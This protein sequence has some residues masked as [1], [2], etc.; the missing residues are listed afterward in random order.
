MPFGEQFIDQRQTGHD[1]R[2]KFTGKERDA[3]TGF[4]YFGA[5]YYDSGLSV[6]FAQP[7]KLHSLHKKDTAAKRRWVDP[8]ADKYLSTSPFMY[9][10]GN[11]IAFIDP[12]GMNH[13]YYENKYGDV[14]YRDGHA[15]SVKSGGEEY[16][17]IGSTYSKDN[18]DGTSTHYVQNTAVSVSRSD[19]SFGEVMQ[20]GKHF[21]NAMHVASQYDKET[22]QEVFDKTVATGTSQMSNDA[23]ALMGSIVVGVVGGE[24]LL[25]EGILSTE[26]WAGKAAISAGS[27]AIM[28]NGDVD[29][30]DVAISSVTTPGAGA[31]LGGLVDYYGGSDIRIAGTNKSLSQTVTDIG[32]GALGS[33]LGAKGFNSTKPFLINGFERGMMNATISVPTSVLG[34]GLNKAISKRR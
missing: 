29:M 7:P 4:D 6:W 30:A 31:L 25:A 12:T 27:Q 32:T 1:I 20:K 18:G 9:V 8:L 10:L 3:E 22:V 16:K 33:K 5:R 2:F 34:S 24:Y 17:N 21:R 14:I 11:P 19:K 28:N 26:F 13:D 15:A 23:L